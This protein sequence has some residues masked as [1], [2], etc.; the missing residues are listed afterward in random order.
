MQ[1]F[2]MRPNPSLFAKVLLALLVCL[3]ASC[4]ALRIGYANGDTFVYWWLDGYVD[5][6]SEQKPW[7]RAHIDR[8]FAWHRKT[9]LPEY[10]QLLSQVQQ[11]LQH[12]Q[13]SQADVL[14]DITTIKKRTAIVLEQSLPELADLALSLQPEQIAY[15][16]RKFASN[17]DKYRKEYL[18]GTLEDRQRHRYKQI[19]KHAEHW[20]GDFSAQQEAQIRAASDAR[21]LNYEIWMAE[22]MR[23][24]QEMIGMLKKIQST[25]PTRDTT[26]AILRQ[27]VA[28]SLEN[29]TY[30]ENK[31]F[32]DGSIE[33]MAQ[34]VSVIVNV[35]TPAQKTHAVARLQKLID[36]CHQLAAKT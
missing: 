25:R 17:N 20:F 30:A 36:D 26:I 18:Q 14:A 12:G 1:N 16:E 34:A 29:F 9:Q 5:F 19:M 10:A 11:R 28:R 6:T 35:A 15:L 27:F 4:S 22:R 32:F 8:L 24:Q 7:V 2:I 33:G 23:R 13:T 3:L 31:A 21:P